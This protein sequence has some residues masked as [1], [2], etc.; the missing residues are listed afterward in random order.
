MDFKQET[1]LYPIKFA[2]QT[3][4]GLDIARELNSVQNPTSAN[5]KIGITVEA[6]PKTAFP[7]KTG[8]NAQIASPIDSK[9]IKTPIKNIKRKG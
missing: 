6:H 9:K 7:L 1:L 4:R 3:A 2:S 8:T 5:T